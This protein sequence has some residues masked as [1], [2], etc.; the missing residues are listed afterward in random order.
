MSRSPYETLIARASLPE[1]MFLSDLALAL[2]VPE[3]RALEHLLSGECGP[4]LWIDDRPALLRDSFVEAL[5]CRQS[6]DWPRASA[7]QGPLRSEDAR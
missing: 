3:D 4:Y 2:R 7:E 5:S 1:V 6:I